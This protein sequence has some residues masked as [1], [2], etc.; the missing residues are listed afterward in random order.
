MVA[1]SV[2]LFSM[3]LFKI[4]M[5]SDKLVAVLAQIISG[6]AGRIP[7][8]LHSSLGSDSSITLGAEPVLGSGHGQQVVRVLLLG[9][10]QFSSE[11]LD[12]AR[13]VGFHS[14]EPSHLSLSEGK[15]RTLLADFSSQLGD[16]TLQ[17]FD[18]GHR[19]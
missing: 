12:G 14:F 5:F 6:R 17:I 19:G 2:H 3:M 7:F 10:T 8:G 1:K 16:T 11:G 13:Q 15:G 18:Q 9:S 4:F